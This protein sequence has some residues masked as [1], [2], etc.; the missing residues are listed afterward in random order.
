MKIA[1]VGHSTAMLHVLSAELPDTPNHVLA[2]AI[3]RLL[4]EKKL[5]MVQIAADD[6]ITYMEVEASK[7][8]R[9]CQLCSSRPQMHRQQPP[10][11]L[12]LE[13]SSARRQDLKLALTIEE[14]NWL[15][16]RS[17]GP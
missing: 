10:S 14:Q 1:I 9:Y 5:E 15:S 3:N 12:H 2:S 16:H 6:S 13:V 4:K 17:V 7:S 8:S 11:G